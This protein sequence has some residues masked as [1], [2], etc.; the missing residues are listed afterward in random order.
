[1]TRAYDPAGNA[2]AITDPLSKVTTYVYDALNRKIAVIDPLAHITTTVLDA[3]GQVVATMDLLRNVSQYVYDALHQQVVQVDALGYLTQMR[4]DV[5]GNMTA[6]IDPV[7]NQTNYVFNL[8]NR[9]IL[10]TD[11]AGAFTTTAY[12]AASRKT[13]VIDRDNRQVT[14]AYDAA[15][16]ETG[17]TWL[18]SPGGSVVN[19]VTFTY[20]DK[21]NQLTA[22][23][24]QGTITSSYDALDRLQVRTDLYGLTLTYSYDL[25]DRT[26]LLQDSKGGLTTAVFDNANRLTSRQL[27]VAAGTVRIDPGYN[28]RNELSSLTRYS[29]V[30]GS[31]VVGTTVYGYDDAGKITAITNKS[32]AGATLSYYNYGYVGNWI[33]Q[34]AWGSGGTIG[35]HTYGNDPTGQLTNADSTNYQFDA[36]GNRTMVGYQT[37]VANRLTNDGVFTYTYDGEGNLTQ[38]SKGSGLETWYYSYDHRNLLTSVRQTSNGTTNL[39]TLTYTY[40]A[41]NHLVKQEKW[42]SGGSTV[43][44]RF[45]YDGRNVWAELDGSNNIQVRY[46]WG[47]GTAQLFARIDTATEWVLTDHLGTVR[48]IVS[49]AG[50]TVLDHIEYGAFGD[51]LSET[52]AS[53]SGNILY[54]GLRQDRDAS[55]V[56]ASRRTLLVTTG[57]WVQ[58]DPIYFKAG[59][60]NLRRYAGNNPTNVTDP[61][62]TIWWVTGLIGAAIGAGIGYYTTGTWQGAVVGGTSGFVTGAT[63]GLAGPGIATTVGGGWFG[64]AVAGGV[65]SGV[66]DLAGQGMGNILGTQQGWDPNRTEFAVGMGFVTGGLLFRP[67]NAPIQD[68]THYGPPSPWVQ[69]GQSGYYTWVMSGSAGRFPLNSGVTTTVPGSALQYPSGWEGIKGLI[70]QR[71]LN[72]PVFFEW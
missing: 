43:T 37:G 62:G 48:D 47:E 44:T 7:G 35:T 24:A 6:L 42:Q 52:N 60:P 50:T 18:S 61:D 41:L 56:I 9:E 10:R 46:V 72:E 65:S 4:R 27:S 21:G 22:A 45:S 53:N 23:D 71:I 33:S 25:A 5:V 55:I 11:P 70:G 39:L 1:M 58:E 28:N 67:G 15:N 26:T 29:D 57:Q 51:I 31:T 8:L 17:A 13:S 38:K 16:R 63:L 19:Q 59:D 40:D 69:V 49:A 30:A 64:G 36:N 34:E 14:Y 66:G 3:S 20:D 2:T 68:I 54:T 32:G 12:D